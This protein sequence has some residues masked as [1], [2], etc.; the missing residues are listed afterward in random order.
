MT[1]NVSSRWASYD[2][3]SEGTTKISSP[4]DRGLSCAGAGAASQTTAANDRTIMPTT[5]EHQYAHERCMEHLQRTVVAERDRGSMTSWKS[6]ALS[7][8]RSVATGNGV[9]NSR[10][11]A[12]IQAAQ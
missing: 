8:A 9:V 2:G 6:V 3:G 10:S 4:P 7:R 1:P 12:R 5:R 11:H